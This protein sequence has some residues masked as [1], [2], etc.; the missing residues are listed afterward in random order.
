MGGYDVEVNKIG[1]LDKY[2]DFFVVFNNIVK[3][4]IF[5]VVIIKLE[6]LVN[7]LFVN[8]IEDLE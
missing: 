3:K 8:K 7:K 6:D 4:K 5:D 2:E 1:G